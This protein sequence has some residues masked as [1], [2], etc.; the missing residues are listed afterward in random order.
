MLRA[1]QGRSLLENEAREL[2]RQAAASAASS[3]QPPVALLRRLIAPVAVAALVADDDGRFVAVNAAA[4]A[5][6][7]YTT[8]ELARL[9]VWQITPGSSEHEA[10]TLWR[11]FRQRREQ[12]GEYRVLTKRGDI[13]AAEYAAYTDILPGFHLSLLRRV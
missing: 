13:V 8:H 5:L 1:T 7:G 4:T 3:R 6:T 12:Y 10:E 2:V 11:A 9:S